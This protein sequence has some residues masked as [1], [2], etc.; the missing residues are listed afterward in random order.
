MHRPLL[1]TLI[2]SVLVV[3]ACGTASSSAVETLPPIRTTTSTTVPATTI[4][5]RDIVYIVQSGDNVNEIAKAYETSAAEIIRLNRLPES[6]EIFPGQELQ[7]PNVRVDT[8]L[9]TTTTTT[10]AP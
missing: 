6:G 1:L 7:I 10:E 4:D 2:A 3:A 9:P 8:Q 5:P